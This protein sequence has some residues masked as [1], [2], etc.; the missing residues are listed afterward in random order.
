M[1]VLVW[2]G[3]IA[4]FVAV[5]F[6]VKYTF[7]RGLL[8]PT[9]RLA[10]GAAFGFALVGAGQ[11]LRRRSPTVSEA[12]TGAGIAA[13]YACLL[14][15]TTLYHLIS[16]ATGF[17]LTIALTALAI[18]LTL[19][20]GVFVA[21]LGLIGGFLT[22]ALIGDQEPAAGPLFSYLLLLEI[23][24]VAVTRRRGWIG[25]TTL[26]LVASFAW[27]VGFTVLHLDFG[28]AERFWLGGFV[29]GSA[30]IYI[31]GATRFTETGRAAH[32]YALAIAATA[33][34]AVLL[35]LLTIYGRFA[36]WD[37]LLF[38]V[39]G[40][41]ALVLGR[42]QP[43]FLALPWITV[44]V[45]ALML[46]AWRISDAADHAEFSA[47]RAAWL[48]IGFAVL[49]VGGAYACLWRSGRAANWA[50]LASASAVGLLVVGHAIL[51]DAA[52]PA[53]FAWWMPGT[54][55]AMVLIAMA[56]GVM[57][58]R[59]VMRGGEAALSALGIGAAVSLAL[60]LWAQLDFPWWA[61]AWSA[62]GAAAA[63]TVWRWRIA[64][65]DQLGSAITGIALVLI[66]SGPMRIEVGQ[67]LI[68]NALLAAYGL[69]VLALALAA[70]CLHR[71]GKTALHD[72][73]R[74]A[75]IAF[76]ALLVSWL[77]RHGFHRAALLD[78]EL[79]LVEATSYIL[80]WWTLAAAL[81]I[82]HRRHEYWTESFAAR[83]LSVVGLGALVIAFAARCP[84]WHATPMG[85]TPVFNGLLFVYGLPAALLAVLMALATGPEQAQW[86]RAFGATILA[87]LFV[88]V[89]LQVRHFF[90]GSVLAG[91][92]ITQA[93]WYAY[94][95][96]WLV[97][98]VAVLVLGIRL[99]RAGL[100]HAGL[101]VMLLTVGKVF[102][103]DTAHL[104]DLY[105]VL[106]F[107]GLGLCLLGLGYLYQ[108]YV[109]RAARDPQTT[110]GAEAP[111][112][113]DLGEHHSPE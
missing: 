106:S 87:L 28:D 65:L 43:R 86:R 17:V 95:L 12:A 67:T 70:W 40:G 45:T 77:I 75:A 99:G 85:E 31:L 2:I 108:R 13:L 80:A 94:S 52:T 49:Y 32:P 93:E 30:A 26:T 92:D 78:S 84:L 29:L 38:A 54:G 27:V 63:A 98:G 109:F 100:R 107:L 14:A 104:A 81:F 24:L 19:R 22:P 3:G 20:H 56:A 68:W 6:F 73:H 10:L 112:E 102:I 16:P 71:A 50:A 36:L 66:A 15:A 7:E 46:L 76:V 103:F 97:F 8:T 82:A 74:L 11:W 23:A 101:I 83:G 25:L 88:L 59:D 90:A 51:H 41:G 42:A 33:A 53:W 39:L 60:A 64:G 18:V 5:A 48:T 69:P 47:V 113:P 111:G 105:R 62:L 9:M 34:A 44:G 89:S 58:R 61:V 1:H 4:L 79:G 21:L 96:A 91:G 55:A 72:L 35:G 110:S 37:F 57:R